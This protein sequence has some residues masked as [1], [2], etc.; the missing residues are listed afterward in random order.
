M[1]FALISL[2]ALFGVSKQQSFDIISEKAQ[3]MMSDAYQL[4]PEMLVEKKDAKKAAKKTCADDEK[5]CT[6]DFCQTN[7]KDSIKKD[8][9]VKPVSFCA[10]SYCSSNPTKI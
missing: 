3:E 4:K 5:L 1:K 9:K 6:W 8:S 10:A 2:T 7:L